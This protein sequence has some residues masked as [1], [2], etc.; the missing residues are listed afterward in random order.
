[1]GPAIVTKDEVKDVGAMRLTTR[2]N[3]E[4]RQQACVHDL[5]FDIP[6]LL[7][8]ISSG[9]TLEAGDVIATGHAV[10]SRH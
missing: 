6:S 4:L 5:I 1:M 2:V 3:G 7:E 9:I 10:R 8:T